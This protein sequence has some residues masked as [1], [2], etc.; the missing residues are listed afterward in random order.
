L[1]RSIVNR[2]SGRLSEFTVVDDVDADCCLLVRD[3][4]DRRAQACL[5]PSLNLIDGIKTETT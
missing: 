1:P 4:C 3:L 5:A 2:A